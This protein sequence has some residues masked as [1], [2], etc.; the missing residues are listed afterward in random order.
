MRYMRGDY[1]PPNTYGRVYFLRIARLPAPL[2][3]MLGEIFASKSN[4]CFFRRI[5]NA[6]HIHT[7]KYLPCPQQGGKYLTIIDLRRSLCG[8]LSVAIIYHRKMPVDKHYFHNR[9]VPP[10]KRETMPFDGHSS[11]VYE[12]I[13]GPLFEGAL[14]QENLLVK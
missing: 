6:S 5:K 8:G 10:F 11:S 9:R 7:H 4:Y 12:A 2:I 14:R 3:I 13:L 1:V